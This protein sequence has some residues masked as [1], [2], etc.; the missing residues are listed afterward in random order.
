MKNR[1]AAVLAEVIMI[2]FIVALFTTITLFNLSG[3]VYK[4]SFK[5]RAHDLT[6]LFKKAV[7]SAAQGGRRYEIVLDF[8]QNSYL[9]REM[10]SGIVSVEDIEEEEIIYTGQFDEKF[11]LIYVM[12]DDGETTSEAPALFR[13]GKSGWQYGGKIVVADSDGSEYSIIVNRLSRTIEML[14]GDVEIAMP[15][16]ADEMGF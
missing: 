7:V 2:V 12:F 15:Q 3:V 14:N 16:I 1:K 5:S 6:G 8:A 11:Q 4:N 10:I 13:V 9:L